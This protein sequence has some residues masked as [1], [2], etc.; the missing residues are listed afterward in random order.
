MVLGSEVTDGINGGLSKIT[1]MSG[2][3]HSKIIQSS[4]EKATELNHQRLLSNA[5]SYLEVF[6][7]CFDGQNQNAHNLYFGNITDISYNT[8]YSNDNDDVLASIESILTGANMKVVYH[9]A[10]TGSAGRITS[11]TYVNPLSKNVIANST[12][13]ENDRINNMTDEWGEDNIAWGTVIHA[14]LTFDK[15]INKPSLFE[16][17]ISYVMQKGY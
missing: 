1:S 4:K 15:Y 10:G 11:S 16:I 14:L 8:I 6:T 3:F 2:L 13:M 17:N 12:T 5:Q 9:R 7:N